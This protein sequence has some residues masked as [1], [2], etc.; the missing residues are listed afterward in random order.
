MTTR[1][2]ETIEIRRK[3]KC[4]WKYT[5][6]EIVADFWTL[7]GVSTRPKYREDY[8]IKLGRQYTEILHENLYIFTYMFVS[9]YV[10]R[11][12]PIVVDNS[13]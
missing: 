5:F 8:G 11:F 2:R 10:Y 13:A 4:F 1:E 3:M 9:S 12:H 6:F 7:S